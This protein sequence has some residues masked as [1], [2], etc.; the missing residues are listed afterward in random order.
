MQLW[1]GLLCASLTRHQFTLRLF[2]RLPTW[3]A[4]QLTSSKLLKTSDD[5]SNLIE[6]I[7]YIGGVDISYDGGRG[8]A[9]LVVLSFPS[10]EPYYFSSEELDASMPYIPGFLDLREAPV[11]VKLVRDFKAHMCGQKRDAK[12]LNYLDSKPS[13]PQRDKEGTSDSSFVL[14]VDGNGM[15]HDRQ[16]GSACHVGLMTDTITIGVGKSYYSVPEL[17]SLTHKDI[18]QLSFEKKGDVHALGKMQAV[19]LKSSQRAKNPIFVSIGHRI[20]LATATEIVLK[21]C[22]KGRIPEPIKLADKA[23]KQI[24][25]EKRS[26]DEGRAL[27]DEKPRTSFR[28]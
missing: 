16:F 8:V 22:S 19:A 27:S 7:K 2:E 11:M 14:L 6:S 23:T 24:I 20:S 1:R 25:K 26:K 17:C 13:L 5:H 28:K 10:L 18:L 21:C 15:L 9:G 3:M 12:V 4:W